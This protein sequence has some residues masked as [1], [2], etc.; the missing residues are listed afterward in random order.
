MPE[1]NPTEPAR[2]T[3]S[4]DNYSNGRLILGGGAGWFAEEATV[5]GVNFARRW[6][7]LRE[8]VEAMRALWTTDESSY[9]SE[10]IKFPRVRLYPKPVQKPGIPVILVAHDL[11]N[12]L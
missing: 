3:A 2:L 6:Q 7:H 1:G 10:T 12:T 11:K 4:I 9:S 5:M 8:S